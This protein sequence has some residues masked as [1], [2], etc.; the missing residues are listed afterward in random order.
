MNLSCILLALSLC[1]PCQPQDER[2]ASLE[3]QYPAG[4]YWNYGNIESVT[5]QPCVHDSSFSTCSFFN[6]GYQCAG[7]AFVCYYKFHGILCHENPSQTKWVD[8]NQGIKV[9]DVVH[10]G[11]H[12]MFVTKITDD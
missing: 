10:T 11:S 6:N 8:G 9:G 1:L 2:I 4:K 5:D 12:W 7:F 3:A